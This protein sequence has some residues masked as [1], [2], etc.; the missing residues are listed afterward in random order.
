MAICTQN[1]WSKKKLP[2]FCDKSAHYCVSVRQTKSFE[3]LSSV[4]MS[5]KEHRWC[6]F[7]ILHT[8]VDS[9]LRHRWQN[10]RPSKNKSK[11]QAK[12]WSLS[13][14][15]VQ[16]RIHKHSQNKRKHYDQIV[17]VG[18][19]G[20]SC[21]VQRLTSEGQDRKT[22]VAIILPASEAE[23]NQRSIPGFHLQTGR[24]FPYDFP[25]VQIIEHACPTHAWRTW[26]LR[27]T[28]QTAFQQMQPRLKTVVYDAKSILS[29]T[30]EQC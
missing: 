2:E 9:R 8:R 26:L 15:K 18:S 20:D 16:C 30:V 23:G 10:T 25:P 7:S 22:N 11:Q 3:Y 1:N 28:K 6:W 14:E 17:W 29:A 21:W 19:N 4:R 13:A 24:K 12:T 27:Q 5:L